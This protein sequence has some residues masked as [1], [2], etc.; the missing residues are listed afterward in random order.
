MDEQL[1][2]WTASFASRETEAA[3]RREKFEDDKANNFRALL[4]A[5]PIFAGYALLDY[6]MLADA[7]AAVNFRLATCI[8]GAILL[9]TFRHKTLG[10]HQ[11]AL[12]C[13]IPM[14]MSSTL[15]FILFTQG[16]IDHNYYVGLIQGGV[17]VCFLLRVG[18]LG[19]TTVLLFYL[20]GFIASL[21]SHLGSDE[22]RAQIFILFSMFMICGFGNYLL[23]RYR[24][25]DFLKSQTIEVQNEQ[26]KELLE[27]EKKDNERKIAALN[28]LVHFIKTPLHQITGFSDILVDA[29]RDGPAGDTAEN[30][31]YIKNATASLTKSVNGLLTY[32]RLDEAESQNEPE[33]NSISMAVDDLYELMPDGLKISKGDVAKASIFV[34]TNVL[35]AALNG[36]A[37]YYADERNDAT[38]IELS[39]ES[40][41][42]APTLTICDNASVLSAAN[43]EDLVLPLTQITGYLGQ[44]GDELPMALRTVARAIEI[45]G[46]DM[47]HTALADGNRYVLSFPAAKERAEAA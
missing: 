17:F 19:A 46:G 43:Y 20:I 11:E 31:R 40:E 38:Q 7:D 32:H 23:Q 10:R 34:D 22:V 9:A 5:I 13:V 4:L 47:V 30:A 16:N 36:L 26:L 39:T 42:R 33:D 18:F 14:L 8:I 41:G 27:A 44:T 35:R 21:S 45:M 2:K 24:R 3:F 12:T 1:N 37:E 29:M 25:S 28:M 15:F 6:S